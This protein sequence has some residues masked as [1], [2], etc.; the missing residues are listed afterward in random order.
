MLLGLDS[1]G[2]GVTYSYDSPA[3]SCRRDVALTQPYRRIDHES[4]SAASNN[5][6]KTIILAIFAALDITIKQD[7]PCNVTDRDSLWNQEIAEHRAQHLRS[8]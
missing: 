6:W 4:K 7:Q 2:G 1:G 8:S 3:K 5:A